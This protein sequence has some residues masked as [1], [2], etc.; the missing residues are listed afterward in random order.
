MDGD[1]EFTEVGLSEGSTNS[2]WRHVGWWILDTSVRDTQGRQRGG[3]HE[4]QKTESEVQREARSVDGDLGLTCMWEQTGSLRTSNEQWEELRA[5]DQVWGTLPVRCPQRMLLPGSWGKP[6][7]TRLTE[8]KESRVSR[9]RKLLWTG[10]IQWGH[11]PATGSAVWSSWLLRKERFCE[12]P[13]WKPLAEIL[14]WTAVHGGVKSQV[15]FIKF[16]RI[17]G[18]SQIHHS[19]N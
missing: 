1:G 19:E 18:S 2:G 7:D 15:V 8:A 10:Q 6:G 9:S 11:G 17:I 13:G 5:G 14:E 16:P 4:S 12:V 3:V